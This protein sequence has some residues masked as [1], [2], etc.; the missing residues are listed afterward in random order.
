MRTLRSREM[1]GV[2]A[3]GLQRF[4]RQIAMVEQRQRQVFGQ[5]RVGSH[6][7]KNLL[8]EESCT[9]C[10][11]L[12]SA[13]RTALFSAPLR[14]RGGSGCSGASCQPSLSSV[15]DSLIVSLRAARQS[16][17]RPAP[18]AQT[19][20]SRRPAAA[21]LSWLRGTHAAPA[22]IPEARR[23]PAQPALRLHSATNA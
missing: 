14:T 6:G 22:T 18:D 10:S 3:E 17:A 13:G 16:P 9:S 8:G 15:E 21:R 4:T 2:F 11:R 20:S 19:Q 12:A 5:P 1:A 7:G 23:P